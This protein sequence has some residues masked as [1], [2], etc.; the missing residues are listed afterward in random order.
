MGLVEK[1]NRW[2]HCHKKYIKINFHLDSSSHKVKVFWPLTL[3]ILC[4]PYGCCPSVNS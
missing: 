2:K 3:E 1:E 4:G